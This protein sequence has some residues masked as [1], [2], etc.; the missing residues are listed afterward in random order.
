MTHLTGQ[1]T[2]KP[3]KI[4]E[5]RYTT[6]INIIGIF[7]ALRH[8]DRPQAAVQNQHKETHGIAKR[9]PPRQAWGLYKFERQGNFVSCIPY[10]V[11]RQLNPVKPGDKR[12]GFRIPCGAGK[13]GMTGR[14]CHGP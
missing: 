12:F 9:F 10:L 13:C 11:Y 14:D 3:V 4:S 1:A 7:A 5:S 6:P 8:R 2:R